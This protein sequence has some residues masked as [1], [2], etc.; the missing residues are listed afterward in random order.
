MFVEDIAEFGVFTDAS[1]DFY[2]KQGVASLYH[3]LIQRYGK[4]I[5]VLTVMWRE[6]QKF[7]NEYRAVIEF[8]G[9]ILA[10]V[11]ESKAKGS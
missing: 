7:S 5:A 10:P 2:Q 1:R 4:P 3:I 8:T 11:L 9:W 6:Q